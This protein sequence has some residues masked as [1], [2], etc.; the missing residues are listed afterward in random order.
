MSGLTQT[1]DNKLLDHVNGVAAYPQPATP[2]K[3][4]L[5]T[6]NGS[7]AAAGTEVT[8]GSYAAQSIAFAAAAA[9]AAANS[10][11]VVYTAMPA[12]TVVGVEIWDSSGTPQRL[13]WA[14]LTTPKALSSGDMFQFDT[15]A[16]QV[17]LT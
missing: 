9:G 12:V 8:G 13:W 7:A 3:A 5:M 1:L 15:G 14:P 10:A 16:L 2:L 11:G 6:A 4:R 17:G